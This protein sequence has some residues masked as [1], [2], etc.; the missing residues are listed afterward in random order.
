MRKLKAL[1]LTVVAGLT[2]TGCVQFTADLEINR[3]DRVS[4]E[5]T[6]AVSKD[7]INQL[8]MAGLGELVPDVDENLFTP[9]SR[10]SETEV[11]NSQWEGTRFNFDNRDLSILNL[12]DGADSY[13]KVYREGDYLITEGLVI[14]QTGQQADTVQNLPESE[15]WVRIDYPGVVESTN[16]QQVGSS[17]EWR[18]EP[19][20]DLLMEA[21]VLSQFVESN[22]PPGPQIMVSEDYLDEVLD[23]V[24]EPLLRFFAPLLT[25][26]AIWASLSVAVIIFSVVRHGRKPGQYRPPEEFE[27]LNKDL[28]DK[29]KDE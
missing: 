11:S 6:A 12:S 19:G 10:V 22:K 1:A 24:G 2:L 8:R 20:E 15:V 17:I 9:E 21:R 16:G 27:S 23:Q 18:L 14:D 3:S 13:L 7:L 4:G 25:F 28:F 26:L 5:I 29:D